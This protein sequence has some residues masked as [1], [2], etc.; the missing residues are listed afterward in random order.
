VL[1]HINSKNQKQEV[2]ERERERDAPN[3]T[4]A[5]RGLAKLLAAAAGSARSTTTSASPAA[6]AAAERA[7]SSVSSSSSPSSSPSSSS[8]S[9]SSRRSFATKPAYPI[10]DH[11]YDAI[12]VGAGGAGLRA[13][14]GLSEQGLKTA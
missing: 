10:I 5:M 8:S 13:A 12:V 6:A 3:K 7:L 4:N 14:V 9:S 1:T 2:A 11:Q